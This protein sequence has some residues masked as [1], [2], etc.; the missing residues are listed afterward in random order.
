MITIIDYKSGNLKS[1][2]NAL[3]RLNIP[4][5]TAS[6]PADVIKAEKIIF[7]GVGAAGEAMKNLRSLNLISPIKKFISSNSPFLG[8]CL[9]AQIL[10]EKS[11]E[12]NTRCLGVL[13]G[14]NVIFPKSKVIVPHMGW[15]QVKYSKNNKLFSG[16]AN[17][18][19]FYFVHS[20]YL[21]PVNNI[22]IAKTN[23]SQT[24]VSVYNY[25]NIYGVQFHPEKSA[26]DGLMLL[27]NFNNIC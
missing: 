21:S 9:G 1:V 27:K 2:Q 26:D 11:A 20:Y 5:K 14:K 3:D 10:F 25:K 6:R 16:I 7:P 8:I 23:Y 13:K 15:N 24:F 22:A 4:Y 19:Y 18:S 12:N 17:S